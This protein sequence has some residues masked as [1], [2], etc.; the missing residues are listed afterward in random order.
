MEIEGFSFIIPNYNNGKLIRRCIDSI[1]NQNFKNFEIIVIDDGSTDDSLK[2]LDK[3]KNIILIKN[4]KNKGVSYSR[5]VGILNSTKKY[6]VFLDSDDYLKEN[7]KKTIL[8]QLEEKIDL[9]I[10]DEIEM[11]RNNHKIYSCNIEGIKTV[12]EILDTYPKEY[13]RAPVSYWIHNKIFVRSIIIK[14]N[15]K[16]NINKKAAEDQ[17]FCYDYFSHTKN[18][19]FINKELY[20]YNQIDVD[21]YK[22]IKYYHQ[23][24]KSIYKNNKE[25][26]KKYNSDNKEVHLDIIQ[27]FEKSIS[28]IDK[29]NIPI[30][31]KMIYKFLV[32]IKNLNIAL[33]RKQ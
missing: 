33:R 16:F 26:F 10:Y 5:N 2:I 32:Y 17:E 23:T 19:K 12:K 20:Y 24:I 22:Y 18:V 7:Y 25:I 27:L 11:K 31:K 15:I 29:S 4:K 9:Y 1:L 8:E 3:Y 21:K 6:I 13:L 14:N 30:I 28:K